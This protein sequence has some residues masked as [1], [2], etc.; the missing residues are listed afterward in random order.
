MRWSVTTEGCRGDGGG[1]GG[2]WKQPPQACASRSLA[3]SERVPTSVP[4]KIEPKSRAWRIGFHL[5]V[6]RGPPA[7]FVPHAPTRYFRRIAIA[8]G[9]GRHTEAT[10]LAVGSGSTSDR[11]AHPLDE[12]RLEDP[13]DAHGVAEERIG[14][15]AVVVHVVEPVDRRVD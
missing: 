5:S 15:D 6:S 13:V 7:G 4:I 11:R 12:A 8:Q 10:G 2:S 3:A 9:T 14:F 1:G